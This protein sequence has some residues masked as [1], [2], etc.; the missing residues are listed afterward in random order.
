MRTALR[1]VIQL[2]VVLL[3]VSFFS[4]ALISLFPGDPVVAIVGFSSAPQRA[5]IRHEL[6]LDE[7]FIQ[8]YG[9]WLGNF[10][11]GNLGNVYY[12][13][14]GRG[15][16]STQVGQS[17]PISL[18]LMAYSMIIT[19]LIA[20][21]LGV[22]AAYK[23]GSVFDKL[24]NATA[25]G[26]IALPDFALALILSY[27]VGV[28]LR[29]LPSSGYVHPTA[30]LVEHL[31]S[32][33]LPALSLAVGQ[34]AGY[35]R[36]LRSD[37]IATLQEDYILMAKSKGIP[38]RRILWRHAVRPSSLTLLTVAGLNVGA[39]IGG[40]IVVELIFGIPGMGRLL[41]TAIFTRQFVELQSIVALIAIGYVIVNV[42]ID[43]L[44]TVFDPR[45]RDARAIA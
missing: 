31:K 25:F 15:K 22:F 16:V 4:F 32:M 35:M 27:W 43:V 19:L 28:K 1:R 38:T 9:H 7:P 44:Y 21:P 41:A 29:W 5:E 33:T 11:K 34:I 13:P 14:T 20:I 39:L 30:N 10:A 42:I 26:S 2:V 3:C 17:L 6:R 40:A 18:Q 37:M 23:A 24:A 45:I 12:G 8:Q 36:L